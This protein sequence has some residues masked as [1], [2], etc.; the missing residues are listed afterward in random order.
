MRKGQMTG[1]GSSVKQVVSSCR[2]E[3]GWKAVR[4][5]QESGCS[6]NV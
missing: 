1:P 6:I 5:R 3:A 4:Q 2:L